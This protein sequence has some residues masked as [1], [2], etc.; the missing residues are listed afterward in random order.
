[1]SFSPA[2]FF[3]YE[4]ANWETLVAFFLIAGS[5]AIWKSNLLTKKSSSNLFFI[6][7]IL[8]LISL[9][10][11][12]FFGILF[13]ISIFF[14]VDSRFKRYVV[15]FSGIM[16]SLWTYFELELIKGLENGPTPG[17]SSL[18]LK[19]LLQYWTFNYGFAFAF[20]TIF[21][22][23]KQI[24]GLIKRSLN[25][26]ESLYTNR[27]RV[28]LLG[29]IFVYN[30]TWLLTSNVFYRAILISPLLLMIVK[31]EAKLYVL[32]IFFAINYLSPFTTVANFAS[33]L[34]L[35]VNAGIIFAWMKHT[36]PRFAKLGSR[37]NSIQ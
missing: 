2:L 35:I 21:L 6:I 14:L 30:V 22:L 17:T 36:F 12:K 10:M 18:G 7:S 8:C 25:L 32:G 26:G 24:Y 37:F 9:V 19:S 1:M 16:L 3:T 15:I 29:T 34:L 33:V 31:Y 23:R 13:A 11:L 20:L 4:R 28:P 5:W 27:L